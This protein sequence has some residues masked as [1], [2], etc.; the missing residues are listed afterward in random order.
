MSKQVFLDIDGVLNPFALVDGWD[1]TDYWHDFQEID[2]GDYVLFY[3]PSM[4]KELHSLEVEI[5]IV[6]T[7]CNSKPQLN[8]LLDAIGLQAQIAP[9][10]QT[11]IW[12]NGT[13]DALHNDKTDLSVWIDDD[14]PTDG[15]NA[16]K[17]NLLK[18]EPVSDTGLTVDEI[19]QA[20]QFLGKT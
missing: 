8:K 5:I 16:S 11:K 7:W 15:K 18:I 12:K 20:R 2:L 9:M 13:V 1:H 6:S 4:V 10:N 19:D 14:E 3:S 17:T